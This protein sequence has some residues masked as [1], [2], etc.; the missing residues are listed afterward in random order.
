MSAPFDFQ[1]AYGKL[2]NWPGSIGVLA[3]QTVYMFASQCA[4][5]SKFVEVGFDGGRTTIALNWAASVLDAKIIVGVGPEGTGWLNKAIQLYK[6]HGRVSMVQQVPGDADLY[7]FNARAAIDNKDVEMIK[8]N[9]IIIKIGTVNLNDAR[10]SLISQ[11]P[12]VTVWQ[13]TGQDLIVNKAIDSVVNEI[14]G[15]KIVAL[16]AHRSA[17]LHSGSKNPKRHRG[18]GSADNKVHAIV[19]AN[20]AA[21]PLSS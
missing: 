18:G 17:E 9:A 20:K 10:L 11:S 16:D 1:K 3:A 13:R 7:V 5:N 8:P 19:D 6:M 21:E 15:E 12:E 4:P 14:G 2:G